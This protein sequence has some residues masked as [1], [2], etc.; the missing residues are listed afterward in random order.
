M[1]DILFFMLDE[2]F[3]RLRTRDT[4]V[5]K[6]SNNANKDDNRQI[7]THTCALG[8]SFSILRVIFWILKDSFGSFASFFVCFL[9]TKRMRVFDL[10]FVFVHQIQIYDTLCVR[11]FHPFEFGYYTTWRSNGSNP[12]YTII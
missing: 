9:Q 6:D 12:T 5:C 11:E 4:C 8:F 3:L 1:N 7:G 10:C 2:R